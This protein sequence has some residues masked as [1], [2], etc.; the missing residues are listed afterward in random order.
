M[1]ANRAAAV[2]VTAGLA[3]SGL[4]ACGASTQGA[5][6]S[7]TSTAT[8]STAASTT[9]PLTNPTLAVTPTTILPPAHVGGT[10]QV[11]AADP[12][13]PAQVTLVKVVDPAQGADRFAQPV[14][15][16]RFVGVQLRITLGGTAP[17]FLDVNSDTVLDDTSGNLYQPTN[18][19]LVNCPAFNLGP[20]VSPGASVLGCVTF[21]VGFDARVAAITFTPG[22][23]FSNVSAEWVVP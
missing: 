3:L 18:A 13:P 1:R 9:R 4:A 5:T 2:A 19:N 23:P 16:G 12:S 17:R 15:G 10:V 11:P 20:T 6:G 21:Q 14:S 8:A 7:T 22:G